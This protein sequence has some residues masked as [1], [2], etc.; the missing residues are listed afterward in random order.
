MKELS[1]ENSI[2]W[3]LQPVSHTLH[4]P[5]MLSPSC[6]QDLISPSASFSLPWVPCC[7]PHASQAGEGAAHAESGSKEWVCWKGSWQPRLYGE[8]LKGFFICLGPETSCHATL[9]SLSYCQ[10]SLKLDNWIQRLPRKKTNLQKEKQRAYGQ[11]IVSM[12]KLLIKL[13]RT[14]SFALNSTAL[15]ADSLRHRTS[16]SAPHSFYF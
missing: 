15:Q 7:T 5:V 6:P 1:H 11:Y 12:V 9:W 4:I 14:H 16:E 8:V 13:E 2:V 10:I 3:Y